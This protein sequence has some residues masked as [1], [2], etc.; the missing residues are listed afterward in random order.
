MFQPSHS[1]DTLTYLTRAC[2][3]CM[4]LPCASACTCPVLQD[5]DREP[6]PEEKEEEEDVVED[7]ER[8]TQYMH[9]CRL[10]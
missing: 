9:V 2:A 5:V 4:Y 6:L 8:Y 3:F 10:I 1:R 7:D